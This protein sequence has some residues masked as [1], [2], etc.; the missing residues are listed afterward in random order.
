MTTWTNTNA[1]GVHRSTAHEWDLELVRLRLG[2]SM[3]RMEM[4]RQIILRNNEYHHYQ[5]V[6]KDWRQLLLLTLSCFSNFNLSISERN[7]FYLEKQDMNSKFS[8]LL[9]RV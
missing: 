6:N 8:Q 5:P 4:R 1:N 2:A 7:N 3:K 9:I